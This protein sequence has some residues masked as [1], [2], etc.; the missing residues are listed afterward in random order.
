MK[1]LII[2]IIFLASIVNGQVGFSQ[3]AY[4]ISDTN[5]LKTM[6]VGDGGAMFIAGHTTSTADGAG[7]YIVIDSAYA[8]G[9]NAFDHPTRGKQWASVMYINNIAISGTQINDSLTASITGKTINIRE[10]LEDV[11]VVHAKDYCT[12]DGVTDDYDSLLACINYAK[13]NN[14]T[15]VIL[16]SGIYFLSEG[17]V[18]SAFTADGSIMNFISPGCDAVLYCDTA[19]FNGGGGDGDA[20]FSKR[21][22]LYLDWGDLG[23]G[24]DD[25]TGMSLVYG[26]TFMSDKYSYFDDIAPTDNY[27]YWSGPGGLS[28]A[29]PVNVEKCKFLFLTK[30]ACQLLA[31]NYPVSRTSNNNT[32]EKRYP[33]RVSNVRNS[34][35]YGCHHDAVVFNGTTSGECSGNYFEQCGRVF[36]NGGGANLITRN[37]CFGNVLGIKIGGY[38]YDYPD[39]TASMRY[40]V[41][42]CNNIIVGDTMSTGG[43]DAIHTRIGIDVNQGTGGVNIHHNYIRFFSQYGIAVGIETDRQAAPVDNIDINYNQIYDGINNFA[44][45]SGIFAPWTWGS[46]DNLERCYIG[47][48][49]ITNNKIGNKL[50]IGEINYGVHIGGTQD[51]SIVNIKNNSIFN[52]QVAAIYAPD[53]YITNWDVS[54][55]NIR[56]SPKGILLDNNGGI[57]T[58]VNVEGN[59]FND[60]GKYL[61]Q[62]TASYGDNY[63]AIHLEGMKWASITNNK[64]N[65]LAR[66]LDAYNPWGVRRMRA[67]LIKNCT[68]TQIS[69]PKING[70]YETKVGGT[71]ISII[72]S[73]GTYSHMTTFGA[74]VAY[75]SARPTDGRWMQDCVVYRTGFNLTDSVIADYC[76]TPVQGWGEVSTDTTAGSVNVITDADSLTVASLSGWEVGDAIKIHNAGA[77]GVDLETS[78]IRID[79]PNKALILYDV[80]STTVTADTVVHPAP[81]WVSDKL[82]N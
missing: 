6:E 82:R 74:K 41:E 67:I 54:F 27:V 73:P 50:S 75:A 37:I 58:G 39:S 62:Y 24:L 13:T 16:D 48:L 26:I 4:A 70:A 17:V 78:I 20:I 65:G 52:T 7:W 47:N 19:S 68:D 25:S 53:V 15:T 18:T 23:Y 8:E 1:Y 3:P 43:R 40:G 5:S 81:T 49:D 69:N 29:V 56:N 76:L 2:S 22:L 80:A 38:N 10:Y 14:I 12:R 30:E 46:I 64:I 45:C 77:V 11:E 35:F 72:T 61:N 60:M 42:V 51:T 32:T 21:W 31:Q 9:E 44:S 34:F 33:F 59:T 28:S 63:F 71:N 66:E 36:E 55:N 57:G 79:V